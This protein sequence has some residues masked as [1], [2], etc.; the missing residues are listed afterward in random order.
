MA[1]P[2]R[3]EMDAQWKRELKNRLID[4]GLASKSRV[5]RLV[6]QQ[7]DAKWVCPFC[8]GEMPDG[9]PH[10]SMWQCCGEIGH[11]VTEAQMSRMASD[12]EV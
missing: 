7:P 5:R 3:K 9:I 11:A 10:P 4:K 6:V 8:G 1:N 2:L 12:A